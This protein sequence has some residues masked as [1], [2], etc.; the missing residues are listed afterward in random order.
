LHF[1]PFY[2]FESKHK[3][4]LLLPTLS[5]LDIQYFRLISPFLLRLFHA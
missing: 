1:P 4:L 5:R 2:S 3:E